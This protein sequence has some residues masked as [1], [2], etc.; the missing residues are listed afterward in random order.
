MKFCSACG[1]PVERRIPA[2]DERERFVCPSC[3]TI[4]YQNPNIVTGCI[5]E[6]EDRI[7]LCRRAIEPRR[8][9]W[10]LPAGFMENGESTQQGAARETW[11]EARARVEVIELYSLFNLPHID[12]VYLLFRARM[13]DTD[14]GPGPESLE[15]ALFR[16]DQIPW[17]ELAFPVVAKTLKLYFADRHAGAYRLKLGDIERLPGETRDYRFTLMQA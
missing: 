5:P 7:L 14:F 15:V 17:D 13:L 2:G 6:W 16:E 11:E 10:T 8:G 1:A 3:D 12:Q 9:L 4:H